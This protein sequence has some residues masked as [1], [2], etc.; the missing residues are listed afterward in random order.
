MHWASQRVFTG[1]RILRGYL[2][3]QLALMASFAMY[4][5]FFSPLAHA[6][7]GPAAI[8]AGRSGYTTA[9][10]V[11]SPIAGVLVERMST[12]RVLIGAFV[13]RAVI[14]A[15]LLPLL[16]YA[17]G[18]GWAFYAAFIGLMF[19][20][21]AIVSINSLVDI[22]QGGIDLLGK[23]YNIAVGDRLRNRYN[24][25]MSGFISGSRIIVV[26][27]MAALGVFAF[28][29]LRSATGALVF[30]MAVSFAVPCLIGV[31]FYARYIPRQAVAPG[32]GSGDLARTSGQIVSRLADGLRLSW[33][34]PNVRSRIGL[35]ACERV[36]ED[37]F[38]FL[39]LTEFGMQALA[40][41]NAAWGALATSLLIAVGKL[42]A[43]I[44]AWA[45]HRYWRAPT[46]EGARYPAYRMFFPMAFLATVFTLLMPVAL[47]LLHLGHFWLGAAI[48]GASNLLF[49]LLFEPAK[50]GFRT[51]TQG[52]VRDEGAPGRIFGI[53]MTIIMA[54]NAVGIVGLSSL[55]VALTMGS[56]LWIVTGLYAAFGLFE[57]IV[58]PR[59]LF[60]PVER[61]T[62][63]GLLARRSVRWG[64][65]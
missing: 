52:L 62:A 27:A 14:W 6:L 40:P 61:A 13:S 56:A 11:F 16:F 5:S 25:I 63:R 2:R 35:A 24:T 1:E 39:V 46:P 3:G 54:T 49:N 8:G 60:T 21:G 31:Y 37:S 51:Y 15:G 34:N 4:H 18:A 50:L 58:A 44:S 36:V 23:Q 7:A 48:A 26:P 20:D 19:L 17:L 53:Q 38:V 33:T 55:F 28:G 43:L 29:V 64:S 9:V 45:M 32:A 57:F 47:N 22:D 30:T 12:R 41:R 10:A 65:G 42:G 59:L